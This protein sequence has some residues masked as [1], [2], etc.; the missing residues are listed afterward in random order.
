M[1]AG[2]SIGMLEPARAAV[3]RSA[4]T[5]MPTV[6][7]EFT[8]HA[9]RI[10]G[11]GQEHVALAMGAIDD[12]RDVL[13]R[14]H[15][16]CLTGEA[17]G[18]L[19]CDCRPQLELALQHV[20]RERRGVVVYLRGHEGRGIGLVQKLRAYALQDRGCDT[21]QANLALG[22]P[23]DAR[24]YG[25]AAAI[26]RDLGVA[27]LK[28]MTNNPGKRDALRR[29][30]FTVAGRVPL[31]VAPNPHNARYLDTKQR[32]FGH[33]LGLEPAEELL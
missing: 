17:F 3:E 7:G 30:G 5:R 9:Y 12:G 23:A 6:H 16:E 33:L 10:A 21:A 2:T 28:L 1:S 19:R 11:G 22:L 15:S 32:T 20:A 14:V 27:R 13:V 18:S 29:H 31:V 24:D 26:L 8:A 4:T 25:A